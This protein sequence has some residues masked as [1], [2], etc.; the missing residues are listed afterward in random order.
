MRPLLALP[1]IIYSW[2]VIVWEKALRLGSTIRSPALSPVGA[3]GSHV[4]QLASAFHARLGARSVALDWR[5]LPS[6]AHVSMQLV[7]LRHYLRLHPDFG[8]EP[9]Q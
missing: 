3:F 8:I 9:N 6:P 5:D 4:V 2:K 1:V 7:S